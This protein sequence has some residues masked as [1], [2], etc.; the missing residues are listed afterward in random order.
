MGV[1]GERARFC[2]RHNESLLTHFDIIALAHP[3]PENKRRFSVAHVVPSFPHVHNFSRPH[4]R[5]IYIVL[6]KAMSARNPRFNPS[7]QSL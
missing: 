3:L 6:R 7:D 2:P 4:L 5:H 1:C